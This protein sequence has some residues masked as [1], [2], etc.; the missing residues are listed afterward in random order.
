MKLET[1]LTAVDDDIRSHNE[2]RAEKHKAVETAKEAY[3]NLPE[4]A[5]RTEA[6][7]TLRDALRERGEVDELISKAKEERQ[8]L[9]TAL[10]DREAATRPTA[11][12]PDK[13]STVWSSAEVLDN[14]ELRER[15]EFISGTKSQ[16]GSLPIGEVISRDAMVQMMAAEPGSPDVTL[17]PDSNTVENVRRGAWQGIVPQLRRPLRF[18]DLVPVGT[19]DGNF[20]PYTVESGAFTGPV[21]TAEGAA[22]TEISLTYT[23]ADAPVRTIAAFIKVRKQ[24][25]SDFSAL[26]TILDSRLRYM[27]LRRLEAEVLA[28]DGSGQNL[29][30]ILNTSGIGSVTYQSTAPLAEHILSGIT[31]IYLNDGEATGVVVYPT[32]WQRMLTAKA[33]NAGDTAGSYEYLGGGP[34][35]NTPLTIWGLPCV[36][37]Q[38][39]AA[40]TALVGDFPIGTTLMIR[41]G[42]NVLMSDSDQ[43]DFTR[44]RITI[45]GEMRAALPVWRPSMFQEIAL[46]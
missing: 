36:P 46:A 17:T 37:H 22:K 11:D 24:V 18:L 3:G 40:G 21:E 19:T 13:T 28:G 10:G 9:L 5:D 38:A 12:R 43:D 35:A 42:V 2:D 7:A 4:D 32:D 25:L 14:P 34:F 26:R 16:V 23:D 29:T 31:N 45:L 30:G 20:V 27:V 41:E 39:I 8:T 33:H 15:L 44:N 1:K 6:H